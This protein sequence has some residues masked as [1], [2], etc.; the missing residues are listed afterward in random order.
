M[1]KKQET[2][3]VQLRLS[4]DGLESRG[5]ER[6]FRKIWKLFCLVLIVMLIGVTLVGNHSFNREVV[7]YVAIA[8]VVVLFGLFYIRLYRAGKRFWDSIKDKKEPIE[9][10]PMPSW[11]R[12]KRK[13]L[14]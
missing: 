9:L 2:R 14:K 10:E 8:L 3:L 6:E 7:G 13:S 1:A 5:A 4:K 12:N 11:W